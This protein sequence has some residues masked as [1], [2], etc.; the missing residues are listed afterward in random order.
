[1]EFTGKFFKMEGIKLLF[2][3]TC[4]TSLS[5]QLTSESKVTL[6]ADFDKGAN[7]PMNIDCEDNT[8]AWDVEKYEDDGTFE[9]PEDANDYFMTHTDEDSCVTS[10]GSYPLILSDDEC[11]LQISLYTRNGGES[12]SAFSWSAIA[13]DDTVLTPGDID[14]D[15]NT[16]T[17]SIIKLE[18]E[19]RYKVIKGFFVSNMRF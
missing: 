5:A 8:Q 14:G 15:T 10:A 6:I 17:D 9:K 13:E 1:M 18:K 2:L 11:E 7:A 4:L 12:G 3:I 19:S 16:W